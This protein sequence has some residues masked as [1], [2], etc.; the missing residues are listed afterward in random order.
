VHRAAIRA[1]ATRAGRLVA[2]A[3][4]RTFGSGRADVFELDRPAG[5][6]P[7]SRAAYPAGYVFRE[8]ERGEAAA[9]SRVMKLPEAE[10]RRRFEAGDECW[11]VAHGARVAA[12]IWVHDG[13]CYVRG[14][15]YLHEGPSGEK[16]VYGIVTDPADRGKGLYKNALEDL[17]A[18]LFSDGATRL[19]QIVEAGNA[20]VLA[21]IPRLGYRR[22]RSIETLLV[23]GVRR[24]VVTAVE[25][26]TPEETWRVAAPR[27]RFA[28]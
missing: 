23:L 9:C 24:T 12:V 8:A 21:T 22:T 2:A 7:P 15:G 25:R 20:P 28:I 19:V 16:Y 17:A 5:V 4:F 18:R 13:P 27:G 3:R 26:G 11:V 14:L 1:F 6:V 10:S